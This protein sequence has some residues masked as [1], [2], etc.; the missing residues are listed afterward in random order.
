MASLA[1]FL[2]DFAKYPV[3]FPFHSYAFMRA[4]EVASLSQHLCAECCEDIFDSA[5]DGRCINMYGAQL[6]RLMR[7][8]EA[9]W[10]YLGLVALYQYALSSMCLTCTDGCERCLLSPEDFAGYL[11]LSRTTR[12]IYYFCNDPSRSV[13][14]LTVH[15]TPAA[16][17]KAFN[18]CYLQYGPARSMLQAQVVAAQEDDDDEEDVPALVAIGPAP[19]YLHPIATPV[20]TRSG[21]VSRVPL[22]FHEMQY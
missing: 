2:Q 20:V 5:L 21:R 13:D 12:P 15:S 7:C 9:C 4:G 10:R 19:V 1:S 16:A 17:A 3:N 18:D 22:R 14:Y 11:Q 8:N 6:E